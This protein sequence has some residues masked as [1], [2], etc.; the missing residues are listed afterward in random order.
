MEDTSSLLCRGEGCA[1]SGPPPGQAGVWGR[2]REAHPGSA[3]RCTR[4]PRDREVA[5]PGS[6]PRAARVPA[7]TA[8]HRPRSRHGTHSAVRSGAGEQV[9]TLQGLGQPKSAPPPPPCGLAP[10]AHRSSV[11]AVGVLT[12]APAV[13]I[14]TG[15]AGPA[16]PAVALVVWPAGAGNRCALLAAVG[17]LAAATTPILAQVHHWG[18][19]GGRGWTG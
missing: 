6:G 10:S 9:G 19:R 5:G 13:A 14:L 11:Q 1:V 8:V 15:V 7:D 12:A 16:A 17:V 2:G 18:G 3:G 4:H